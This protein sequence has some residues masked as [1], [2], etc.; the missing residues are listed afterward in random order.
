V[1]RFNLALAVCR[2]A[3]LAILALAGSVASS[4]AHAQTTLPASTTSTPWDNT[5]TLATGSG[6]TINLGLGAEYLMVGGGGGG[7]GTMGGGGGGGGVLTGSTALTGSTQVVVG[8]GGG[9][10][11]GPTNWGQGFRGSDSRLGTSLIA[12]GGGFGGTISSNTAFA[13]GTG[14]SGGGGG[15]WDNSTGN[16][17][18]GIAGQGLAGGNGSSARAGGGGGA[19]GIG[20]SGS[21]ASNAGKGGDGIASSITGTS[22]LYGA[23]GGA[24][25][26]GGTA[27]AGGAGGGGSGVSTF[28]KAGDGTAGTG[29]GGGGS[30]YTNPSVF[31][32]NSRYGGSGGSGVVI[33]RYQS[34]TRLASGGSSS[35]TT[36]AYQWER[37]STTGTSTLLFTFSANNLLA[38]QSGAISGTGGLTYNSAGTLEL[39]AANTFTGA[40]RA[41]SG[42]LNLGNV[43]ALQNSTL[44]MNGSDS[45]TIGFTAAGTNTYTLGGLQ[46]SR[47]LASAANSLSVGGNGAST[48]Y[49]GGLSSTGSLTKTGTGTLT[50]SGSNSISGG[51]AINAGTL[52]L[53]SA[54]ALGTTGTISFGGGAL[55]YSASNTTDYSDRFSTAAGQQIAIDT[56]GQNVSFASALTSDSGSL[57]KSGLGTLT[58]S[59]SNTYSGGTTVSAGRLVGTTDSLQG[60]IT[61]SAAVE[62]AQAGNGTYAGNMGGSGSLTKSGAGAV[63]LTGSNAYSGGTTISAGALAV[64]AIADAGASNIGTSGPL[65]LAGGTL[66]Y[67]GSAAATTARVVDISAA[68]TTSTI[69]VAD[70]AGRLTLTG[71]VWN[72]GTAHPNVVLNK[73]GA[74]TLEIAGAGSNVGTSLVVQSGT[75]VLN[76]TLRA[77][78][79]VRGLDAGATL[80]LGRSDQIFSGDAISTTGNIRMTG[81]TLDLNGFNETVNRVSGADFSAAG[82]GVITSA[83][84]ATLTFGNNLAGRPSRFAGMITGSVAINVKGTNPVTLSGDNTYAGT[85]T[86]QDAG[87]QLRIGVGGTTGSLGT[88]AVTNG[89]EL[90]FDR[91]DSVT[92]S[93]AISGSGSLVQAGAGTTTL[94]GV[95][96]YAGPTTITAGRL[97]GST[98]SL[99]GAITNASQLEFA[100]ASAGT[101]AS[102]VSGTGSFTKTGVGNLIL[103]GSSSYT[104]A[105]SIDAGRLSVNGALGTSPVTVLALA[106]LGGSGS[107]AGPVSIASGGT[108]SPGNSIASLATGTA[109]FASG[110]TFEYEVDSSNLSALGTAA[111]LLVVN[112]DLNIGTGTLLTLTDL[113]SSP[114][115]FVEDTTIF[116]LINYLGSWNNGLFTYGTNVLTDGERFMVGAQQ[117]EIDYNASAGGL[118]F[119][120]DYLPSSSFVTITAVP[121]PS[122]VVLAA[123][124]TALAGWRTRRRTRGRVHLTA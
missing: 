36:G 69:G 12:V 122:T 99:P 106:E 93:N 11:Y 97:V 103:T 54:G 121:E 73:T 53:G 114:N 47:N 63:T 104:G 7:G 10:G 108:L 119:T 43:N 100:Q 2:L 49:S 94:S 1:H 4:Q 3:A 80:Q 23:G 96:T 91:S 41:Q 75:V 84:P 19:G 116:A 58:L 20:I 72:S 39:T 86:I 90:V 82:T 115:P 66:D 31:V 40:T 98:A 112:G 68:N 21:A 109:T 102:A 92:V 37:F 118:N 124:G 18:V 64:A 42:L 57:T 38:T 61:N 79:E 14:G 76:A 51:A 101:F 34:A 32:D 17:S 44:D 8:A 95:N 16:G 89:G 113:A 56:N 62:F 13:S 29:S 120:G 50:L 48:T 5:A 110:A 77:V 74:G 111:D 65:T 87:T 55:Q 9:G 117:W 105:T 46:G 85:T 27:G 67:T 24:G 59:G 35:G 60:A 6:L 45:G 33:V 88:G 52:A 71:K 28:T 81:G 78:Y 30:G 70:P 83:A 15:G 107:I 123:L 22:A 25:S 26:N